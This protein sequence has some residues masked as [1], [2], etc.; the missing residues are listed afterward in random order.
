MLEEECGQVGREGKDVLS[1]GKGLS[2]CPACGSG[3][4]V[5]TSR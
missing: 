4:W 2:K 3:Q 1:I 5:G